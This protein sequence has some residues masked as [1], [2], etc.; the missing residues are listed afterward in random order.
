MGTRCAD[1]VTPLYPQKLALTSPTGGGRSVGIVRSRTKATEFFFVLEEIDLSLSSAGFYSRII[2]CKFSI[3]K[4]ANDVLTRHTGGHGFFLT[5]RT[6]PF[7]CCYHRHSDLPW[8]LHE[9]LVLFTKC[10]I[11]HTK[12]SATIPRLPYVAKWHPTQQL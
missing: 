4:S 2:R 7:F 5:R 8:G 1:Q 6:D 9:T 10:N 3:E 12:S 11:C